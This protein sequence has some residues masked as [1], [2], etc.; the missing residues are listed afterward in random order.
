MFYR[1]ETSLDSTFSKWD[2]LLETVSEG[3]PSFLAVLAEELVNEI[4]R[5]VDSDV[6]NDPY[7]EGIH[8]WLDHILRAKTWES[9]R[10]QLPLA[11]MLVAMEDNPNHWTK[12]LIPSLRDPSVKIYKPQIHESSP[13]QH[14]TTGAETAT[15]PLGGD[16]WDELKAYG[17]ESLDKW[18]CRPLGV[19]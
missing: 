13:G 17:W 19:A 10:R 3:H 11:Y 12:P 1:I 8:L 5:P 14:S 15:D 6:R 4:T 9:R 7:M 16:D 18:T 2:P